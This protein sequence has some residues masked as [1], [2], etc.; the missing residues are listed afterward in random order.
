M[1]D[2]AIG[3]VTLDGS[4]VS[5][6]FTGELPLEEAGRGINAFLNVTVT[7]EIPET[8]KEKADELA[9]KKIG[10]IC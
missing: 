9:K 5:K 3:K 4:K 1:K 10:G 2:D 7:P 8:T 6:G